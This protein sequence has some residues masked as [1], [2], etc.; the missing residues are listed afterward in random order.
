MLVQLKINESKFEIGSL[1]TP[2]IGSSASSV[3]LIG[4]KFASQTAGTTRIAD[5]VI[6]EVDEQMT[7]NSI[8]GQEKRPTAQSIFASNDEQIPI[9][10]AP[11]DV[12]GSHHNNDNKISYDRIQSVVPDHQPYLFP[13]YEVFSSSA[14]EENLLHVPVPSINV[15]NSDHGSTN[16]SPGTTS[17]YSFCCIW[18]IYVKIYFS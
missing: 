7:V 3:N 17:K 18:S 5:Q 1:P 4:S 13:S 15:I 12:P 8:R 16:I 10:S 2:P 11:I 14:P 6:E 9:R